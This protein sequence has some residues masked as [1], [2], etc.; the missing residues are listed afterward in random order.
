MSA[1]NGKPCKNCGGNEWNRHG[2]CAVCQREAKR[3][4]RAANPEKMRERDRRNYAKNPDRVKARVRQWEDANPEKMRE[5]Y[6]RYNNENRDKRAEATR[7]W[8]E[9]NPDKRAEYK[10][11]RRTRKTQAGGSFTVGEWKA[12]CEQYNNRCA[13]CGQEK[14]LTFDHV[15]PVS[16]GGTSD[17]SNGQ[18]LCRSCNSS[19]SDKTID[20][21]T[22]GGVKRWIQKKLFG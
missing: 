10:H 13:C 4:Y 16:K 8:Y 3:R 2:H 9:A 20:Y 19:K 18:P 17:I 5:H 15:I 7:R 21:R 1:K 6:R 11:R 14:P 12:L 22:N